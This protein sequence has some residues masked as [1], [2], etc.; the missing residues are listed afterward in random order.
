MQRNEIGALYYIPQKNCL[1][2]DWDANVRPK[3]VKL[4]QDNI[5]E[6]IHDNGYVDLY[7]MRVV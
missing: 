7:Q 4:L 5:E 1:E 6:K 3:A 2:M